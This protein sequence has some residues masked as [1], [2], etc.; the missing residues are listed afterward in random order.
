[1][2]VDCHTHIWESIEQLG[3]GT[4]LWNPQTRDNKSSSVLKAGTTEHL[5]ATKPVDKTVV[6][7][8]K[9]HFLGAE[10]PNT[11]VADY[12]RQ[13]SD[14]LIGF[15]SIDPSHPEEA[16]EDLQKAHEE[17]GMQGVTVWPAAQD[18]HPASTSAM[19]VY[20]EVNRLGMPI[21]FHQ[22]IQASPTTKMEF[23]RPFLID[24]VAREFS[25][26]RIIIAQLGYPWT[27][28]T[29]VLL[30]KHENVLAD[31]SGLLQ[32]PWNAYNALLSAGQS[33][34]IDKL[35]FGSNFPYTSAATCIEALYSINKFCHGT[36]LPTVPREQLRQIVERD[37]LRLL[38]LESD[39]APA[40][41]EPDTTVIKT[42]D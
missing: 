18:F 32:H 35:L 19:R 36:S 22:D 37:T 7:G 13:H 25:N 39:T 2:I 3:H 21:L 31:I 26:L 1:M 38:G 16:I 30:G 11:Y 8:F 4:G 29:L 9:S 27:D 6:L 34:V 12:V 10:V 41:R 20:A 42:D 40:P 28:E 17:L 15:A 5:A 24:E 33:G 14:R 23:A